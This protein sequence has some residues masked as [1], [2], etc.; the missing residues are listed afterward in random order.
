M[1]Q[2][3]DTRAALA[4]KRK[5]EISTSAKGPPD[6]ISATHAA[7]HDSKHGTNRSRHQAK[8]DLQ[9]VHG[10]RGIDGLPSRCVA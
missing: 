2:R 4:R 3:F 5:A 8:K 10:F 6:I 7:S 1:E 9:D